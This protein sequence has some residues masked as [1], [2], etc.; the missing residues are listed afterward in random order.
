MPENLAMIEQ[1]RMFCEAWG[2][3][4]SELDGRS[5]Y[6]MIQCYYSNGILQA[7]TTPSRVVSLDSRIVRPGE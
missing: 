3:D 5:K 6:M 2:V 4:S 1:F 7:M